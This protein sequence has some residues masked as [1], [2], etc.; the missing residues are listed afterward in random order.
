MQIHLEVNANTK[1]L[2]LKYIASQFDMQNFLGPILNR[3]RIFLHN[4]Q[5][6]KNVGWDDFCKT[7]LI[8][9]W[10]LIA[11]QANKSPPILVDRYMGDRSDDYELI[12]FSD[13]SI[14]TY[15]P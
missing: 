1:R 6:D 15:I 12:T 14:N 2:I 3:A 9:E 10:K 5:C 11:E 13:S 8:K 7:D 4:L